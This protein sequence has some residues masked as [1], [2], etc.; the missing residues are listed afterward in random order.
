GQ[1][2]HGRSVARSGPPGGPED[3]SHQPG[4]AGAGGGS[5][6]GAFE[7]DRAVRPLEAIPHGQGAVRPGPPALRKSLDDC[8]DPGRPRVVLRRAGR[9]ARRDGRELP[10]APGLKPGWKSWEAKVPRRS[11]PSLPGD[12]PALAFY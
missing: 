8:P 10:T 2:D 11:G 12:L 7:R 1:C 5:H 4:G 6:E 9:L 3:L